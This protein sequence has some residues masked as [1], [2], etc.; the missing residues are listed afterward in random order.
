MRVVLVGAVHST[1]TAF[2]AMVDAG[3]APALLITLPLSLAHRHSDFVDLRPLAA[4]HGVPL[5]EAAASNSPDTL[6][7]LRA[8]APDLTLVIGWS[9]LC[10][11]DFRDAARLGS[12]G[13]HPSVLPKL[14]GRAVLP[15]TILTGTEETGASLFWLA[16]GADTGDIAAQATFRIDPDRIR[17]RDLYDRQ[18]E[19]LADML[20][21]LLDRIAAGDAPRIPQDDAQATVCA[22]RTAEDGRIDWHQPAATIDRFI[23]AVGPPYPGAFTT[24]PDGSRL[25]ILDSAPDPAPG[26]H[27]A[28]AGQIAAMDPQGWTIMCGDGNCILAT[29]R[30]LAGPPPRIHAI[31]GRAKEAN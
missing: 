2:H 22:K 24:L 23:R 17:V 26:R 11:P 16:D 30:A 15:W 18:L 7:A 12:I 20:P 28:Q 27:I 6:A 25:T 4:A 13:Y 21:P 10:G 29:E 1:E 3:H 8:A 9:Q 5:F 31:L 19:V 14:R